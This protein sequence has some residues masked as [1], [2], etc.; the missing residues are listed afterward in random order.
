MTLTKFAILP[1]FLAMTACASAP[2]W[3]AD[4]SSRNLAVARVSYEYVG[5]NEPELSDMQALELAQNRCNT[6]GFSAVEMIPG[7]LLDCSIEGEGSCALWKVTREYQCST[8][9]GHAHA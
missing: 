7:D 8:G 4:N 1:V 2:Q 3:N 5:S 9:G 6:W